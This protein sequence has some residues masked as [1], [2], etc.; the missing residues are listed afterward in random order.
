MNTLGFACLIEMSTSI[1]RAELCKAVDD[2]QGS[3]W[4][5]VHMC[6][7]QSPST[8]EF[9]TNLERGLGVEPQHVG[10]LSA[11]FAASGRVAGQPVH[12]LV[13]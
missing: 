13:A 6:P 7:T 5:R 3:R 12:E 9:S 2:R 11:S 10:S 4:P 8:I 1:A